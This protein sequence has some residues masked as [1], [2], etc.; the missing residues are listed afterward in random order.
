MHMSYCKECYDE[1]MSILLD[2]FGTMGLVMTNGLI[3]LLGRGIYRAR[4]EFL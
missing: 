4:P 3:I 2:Y 1:S